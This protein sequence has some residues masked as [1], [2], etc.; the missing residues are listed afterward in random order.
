M[1]GTFI[2]D[3]VRYAEAGGLHNNHLKHRGYLS[4][5]RLAASGVEG[6]CTGSPE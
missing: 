4:V 1:Q 3:A 2:D 6:I 5:R